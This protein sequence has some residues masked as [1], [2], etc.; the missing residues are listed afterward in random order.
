MKKKNTPHLDLMV[1][2]ELNMDLIYN[3]VNAFPEL[4]KE[5]IA[6]KLNLTLGSSSAIFAVNS[7][8]LGLDV[9]FCGMIGND[10][11]GQDVLKELK[12]SN[13]DTSF[14]TTSDTHRTGLTTIIRLNND[15][16]MITYPGAME[17]FSLAGIPDEVFSRSRHLHLSSIFLQK[18][19]KK[20]L[21]KI[22]EHAKEHGM[23]VSVDPQWDPKEVWDIDVKRLVSAIDL[24]FPNEKEMLEI[25]NSDSV[26]EAIQYLQPHLADGCIVI[27]QGP[28][29][30]TICHK[31][32]IQHIPGYIN[33]SPADT[34]GAGDSFDAGFISQ[35]LKGASL[36]DCARFGN[37]AGAVSTIEA[38]G[39]EAIKSFES[40]KEIAKTKFSQ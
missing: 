23:T 2:G 7:A 16:A 22:L 28:E 9:G 19:I 18:G 26:A 34:V 25:T 38:G 21:F 31:K 20:D 39:T 32:E 36:E 8:K 14:I 10:S 30:A 33:H 1:I 27:K 11:F 15:R 40:V 37:M 5:K 35:F 13:I 12:A 24:F 4:G 6:K 3:H 17:D 29:G